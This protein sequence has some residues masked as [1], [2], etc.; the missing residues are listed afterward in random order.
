MPGI[1]H[2]IDPWIN[3]LLMLFCW[4]VLVTFK[5]RWWCNYSI[6][7][8]TMKI[9]AWLYIQGVVIVSSHLLCLTNTSSTTCWRWIPSCEEDTKSFLPYDW[10]EK[11]KLGYDLQP[12]PLPWS[13][14]LMNYEGQIWAW[15]M[16]L[17][18]PL[19]APTILDGTFDDFR[20]V[21]SATKSKLRK[22][23]GNFGYE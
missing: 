17:P 13:K 10:L 5:S 22:I 1:C 19:T 15:M 21:E 23:V 14:R 16:E 4:L 2:K 12:S 8:Y 7:Q 11:N 9:N 20:K 18:G 6:L 3:D